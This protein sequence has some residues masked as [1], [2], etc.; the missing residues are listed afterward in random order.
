MSDFPR[1]ERGCRVGPISGEGDV[2]PSPAATRGEATMRRFILIIAICTGVLGGGPVGCET[3]DEPVLILD[4]DDN[5]DIPDIGT[6]TL[7]Y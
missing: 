5:T 6:E 7:G 1:N 2:Y 3:P 4:D